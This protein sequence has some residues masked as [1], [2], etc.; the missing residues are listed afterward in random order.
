MTNKLILIGIGIAAIGLIALPQTLAL[1]AGQ[2]DFYE[3][4]RTPPYGVPCAKCHAD[5]YS[6][7]ARSK[8]HEKVECEGCHILA[9]TY[10][11]A[12][13][14]GNESIHAAGAPAC[15]DCHDGKLTTGQWHEIAKT[16]GTCAG[17]VNCHGSGISRDTT[18]KNATSILY[19]A[20]E[21][22]KKFAEDAAAPNATLLK[23][24]NEACVGC[25]THTYVDIAW[26]RPT[27]LSFKASVSPKGVWDVTNFTASGVKKTN[28]T[29]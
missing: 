14:G 9:L 10:K 2:H 20:N 1:F 18:F 11:G 24:A 7:L 16:S 26:E 21:S 28:T 12:K 29:G 19:G 27:N 8:V 13:V 23:G 17:G 3:T 4:S 6:E 15:M 22:H 5:V 25:H